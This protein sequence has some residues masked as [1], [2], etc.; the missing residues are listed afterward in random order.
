M[1]AV[2]FASWPSPFTSD[3]FNMSICGT[4]DAGLNWNYK[5]TFIRTKE[6][7]EV[8]VDGVIAETAIYYKNALDRINIFL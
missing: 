8:I 6:E 2:I 5:D 3:T 7:I 1:D 4:K